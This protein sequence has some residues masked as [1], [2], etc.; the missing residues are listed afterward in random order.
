MRN[1]SILGVMTLLVLLTACSKEE[2]K[3][4]L[5]DAKAKTQ[6]VTE[7]A[8]EVVEAQLPETGEVVL[9][10]AS[11]LPATRKASVELISFPDGRP[12]VVQILT[13]DLA[14][15]A[16]AA[17]PKVLIQGTTDAQSLS[18]LGG[19]K[20][21]CDL[22][23]TLDATGNMAMTENGNQV[24]VTFKSFDQVENT[25]EAQLSM[26]KMTGTDGKEVSLRGGRLIAVAK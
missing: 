8:T 7:K 19:T 5:D 10:M 12:T 17:Y 23:V 11:P 26:V 15:P 16:D 25:I 2:M 22:Y 21:K 20:V 18:S 3:Q 4:A 14:A 13:Y 9:E 24:L 6:E 1:R